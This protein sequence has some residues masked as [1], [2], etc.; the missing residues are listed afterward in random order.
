MRIWNRL[1]LLAFIVVV[2]VLTGTYVIWKVSPTELRA[3]ALVQVAARPPRLL[4][5][6]GEIET[7]DDFRR[8]QK[9]QEVLVKSRLVVNAALQ[10]PAVKGYRIIREQIDPVAWL[11]R[12]LEVD[13]IQDSEIME[14]ALSGDDPIE[15]AGLVNAVA[16]AYVDEVTN[17]GARSRADRHAK[18]QKI[19]DKYDEMLKERRE[20]LRANP[21]RALDQVALESEIAAM[22]DVAQK[23][24]AELQTLAVELAAP[25]RVRTIENAVPPSA[26]SRGTLWGRLTSR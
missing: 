18:L 2:V 12:S 22:A 3:R 17:A 26:H 10:D 13:F 20:R 9:N 7:P 5:G 25:P 16:K 21:G 15:I 8:D 23:I 19:K 14:I 11:E 6:A 24:G 4:F 1:V